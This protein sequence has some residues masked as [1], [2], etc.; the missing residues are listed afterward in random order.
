VAENVKPFAVS[1][2]EFATIPGAKRVCVS[3]YLDAYTVTDFEEYMHEALI[4]N[5]ISNVIVDIGNL[6]YVSSAGINALLILVQRVHEMDGEL[7][8]L[9]PTESIYK[10][11]ELLGFN[12][13]FLIAHSEDEIQPLLEG[14]K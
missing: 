3:G 9:R 11:L 4:G 5:P 8:L 13:I 6:N 14:K 1:I 10:L 12:R 2:E 7:V